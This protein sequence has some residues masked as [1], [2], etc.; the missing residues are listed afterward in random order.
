MYPVITGKSN[1]ARLTFIWINRDR[2]VVGSFCKPVGA[3]SSDREWPVSA[4]VAAIRTED[5]GHPASWMAAASDWNP[6]LEAWAEEART[7]R[8]ARLERVT[9]SAH[10][11]WQTR[12]RRSDLVVAYK[13]S[14]Y[15]MAIEIL[16]VG[17][18]W[19][20]GNIHFFLVVW[21]STWARPSRVLKTTRSPLWQ[22]FSP[23]STRIYQTRV[24]PFT[25]KP[26][27]PIW[28][29][30]I[31]T[32]NQR[33]RGVRPMFGGFS[34]VVRLLTDHLVRPSEIISSVQPRQPSVGPLSPTAAT[35]VDQ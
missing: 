10:R 21:G 12:A 18:G 11:T 33:T 34:V 26:S 3:Y 22:E 24:V 20:W 6:G 17:N 15:G 32:F 7:S 4:D 23:N 2:V 5:P 35:G 25:S 8:G 13:K 1:I 28:V 16:Y 9:R 27:Q 31:R 14:Q 30:F 19:D 29:E